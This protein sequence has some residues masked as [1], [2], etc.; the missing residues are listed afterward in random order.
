M[1]TMCSMMWIKKII[2]LKWNR[3]KMRWV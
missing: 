2:K 1:E 3:F